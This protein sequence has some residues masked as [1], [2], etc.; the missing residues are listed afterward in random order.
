MSD[1]L[2]RLSGHKMPH[3]D[4][5][6]CLDLNLLKKRDEATANVAREYRKM[7]ETDRMVSSSKSLT[8][9]KNNA[10]DV[11]QQ[12]RDAS[13][14]LRITG[15][16]R[17]TYNRLMNEC[18]PRKGKQEAF[19]SSTFFL[20]VAKHSATYVDAAGDVHPISKDEWVEIDKIITD[21]EHD[22]LASAVIAV[23]REAGGQ[24]IPLS[25][26]VSEMT[27]DSSETSDSPAT[28]ASRR[29]VSGGGSRKKSTPRKSS[30]AAKSP[31]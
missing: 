19:N 10:A 9:A 20:H 17:E 27:H 29:A 16:N 28:S 15:V 25:V 11:D 23:N 26:S 18:P 6:I 3:E 1:L 4:V 8:V 5:A 30:T 7:K 12:I 14:V 21:G 24:A 22:R 13:I 2:G 31:E